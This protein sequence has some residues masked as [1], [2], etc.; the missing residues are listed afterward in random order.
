MTLSPKP[1]TNASQTG[2]R[3]S[4]SYF[5]HSLGFSLFIAGGGEKKKKRQLKILKN[6]LEFVPSCLPVSTPNSLPAIPPGALRS[7][8]LFPL[9]GLLSPPP[10]NASSRDKLT[11][12]ALATP[13]PCGSVKTWA[14]PV[15]KGGS[16]GALGPQS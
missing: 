9:R 15:S 13:G 3:K 16:K 11:T 5:Y 8:L 1:S 6:V 7:T 2:L 12:Q 10:L 4:V 14:T